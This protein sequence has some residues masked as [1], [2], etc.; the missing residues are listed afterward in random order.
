M[1]IPQLLSAQ[2]DFSAGEL[3]P[4]MKRRD[5]LPLT[6]A[7]GRQMRDW[8]ILNSGMIE[9]RP[10]R[11]ALYLQ[12][13]RVDQISV[14]PTLTYDICFDGE[15]G[16]V[17]R[18]AAGAIVAAQV[19]GTYPWRTATVADIVWTKVNVGASQ[20]DVVITFPGM[21][22]QIAS[23]DGAATWTFS[24]FAFS[25]DAAGVALVPFFRVA[26]P[27]ATMQPSATGAAGAAITVHFSA[28]VLL[29]AHVGTLFRFAGR[30]IRIDAVTGSQDANAT[31]L[32]ALLPTQVL[33]LAAPDGGASGSGVEGFSLGQ[34]VQGTLSNA[35]GEV[36]AI[37]LGANQIAV[38][39]TNFASGFL[40][41]AVGPPAITELVIGPA[42]KSKVTAV[43]DIAPDPAVSWDEQI[44]SDARG[45]PQSCATDD[46]RLIFCDLP[47][48]P[49]A[50]IWSATGQPY[51]F[52]IGFQATDAIC[53]LIAGK[54]RVYHVG[55]W[56]DEL[57]FTNLGL[58]F[59]PINTTNPLKPGSV[60]FKKFSPEAASS[61]K[62]LFT[63]D[64]YLYVNEGRNSVKVIIP[65]G[66]T[67][68]TKPYVV[69]DITQYHKHLFAA[70]PVAIALSTGD[71]QVPERYVY[72]VNADGTVATGKYEAGRQ[73]VGWVP[74]LG[75]GAVKWVS[76]LHSAVRFVSVYPVL[77]TPA[78]VSVGEV[79]DE[80]EYV[81]A[82]ILIN[83]T[84]ISGYV[85]PPAGK[86]P[87]Y[88]LPLGSVELMDG[89]R[90]LGTHAIDP[91]GFVTPAYEGEDLSSATITGGL[92]Y[93]P[94]FEPFVPNAQPG[95]DQ[96]QRSLRRNLGRV[97]V[98]VMNSTGFVI[99]SL[100]AGK[101]GPLL[102]AQGSV[103]SQFRVPP[104]NQ[105]DDQALAP[106]L[107]EDTY[108]QR[109]SGRAFD[110]RVAV[111]KDKPGPLRLI[112]VA[113][114]ASV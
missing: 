55:P 31:C 110:Q 77:G 58:Y 24:A 41:S 27:G 29:P 16:L 111:F 53:E 66:S 35:T 65:D 9:Q 95:P 114:E 44:V 98:S 40:A 54:P 11:R 4:E 90:P 26:A 57:I 67:L 92:A 89:V 52:N 63:S 33:T 46:S 49:S 50:I 104:W 3:D 83:G 99:A 84:P 62:P 21:K 14:T 6:K 100:Y 107:R 73:W 87:F 75:I 15:G 109:F 30:R 93:Q 7:G 1:P 13:G 85:P 88:W 48:T 59:V 43:T 91:N 56:L 94:F 36:V 108:R 60:S 70:G 101:A 61:V 79:L 80:G 2:R 72:V 105:G 28:P 20:T 42:G 37:S 5:D 68:S 102:P 71:G 74:W 82:A 10:G 106:I 103:V 112:E 86:G 17:I 25:L 39:L 38:Q 32:D 45:W 34:A 12:T 96:K 76:A 23:F 22:P 69:T 51:N 113:I 19:A 47:G 18:N 8:R 97:I 81:D 64:G 78:G